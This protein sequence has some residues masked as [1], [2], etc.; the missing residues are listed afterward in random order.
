MHPNNLF[1][2]KRRLLAYFPYQIVHYNNSILKIK[3]KL[4]TILAEN[5]GK[6]F[7]T[8]EADTERDNYMDAYEAKEY[9]LI[10]SVITKPV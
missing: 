2:C 10:D 4:N 1:F 6:P 5:T 8:V 7:E 9:G 3:K